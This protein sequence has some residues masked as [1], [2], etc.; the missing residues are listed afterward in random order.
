M[1]VAHPI[2]EAYNLQFVLFALSL[3]LESEAAGHILSLPGIFNES[4][5]AEAMWHSQQQLNPHK[6]H[7]EDIASTSH[8]PC[9]AGLIS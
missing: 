2:K 7:R 9:C 5:N 1:N 6:Q 4:A 3:C 8:V